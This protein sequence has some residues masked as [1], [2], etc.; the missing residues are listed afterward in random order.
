MSGS[1]SK[2]EENNIQ[3]I[4]SENRTQEENM[5][6]IEDEYHQLNTEQILSRSDLELQKMPDEMDGELQQSPTMNEHF[7]KKFMKSSG[8]KGYDSKDLS[9]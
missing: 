6:I 2:R 3:V 8:F 7:K 5:N 9:G 1:S 4:F